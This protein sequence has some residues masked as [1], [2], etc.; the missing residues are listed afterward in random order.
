MGG[1][2]DAFWCATRWGI[3]PSKLPKYRPGNLTRIYQKKFAR[4]AALAQIG[5]LARRL[6]LELT[7]I[8]PRSQ[9]LH[10]TC[11]IKPG[12]KKYNAKTGTH[13]FTQDS[14]ESPCFV[15][16]TKPA[17]NFKSV[18]CFYEGNNF[19]HPL[20]MFKLWREWGFFP[21]HKE[22]QRRV[23]IGSLREP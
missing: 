1:G 13:V 17:V 15:N 5:E 14:N 18:S 23:S 16:C 2:F 20:N 9:L 19:K 4:L 21:V 22:T 10:E 11:L 6:V 3:W 7:Y 8:I 12:F